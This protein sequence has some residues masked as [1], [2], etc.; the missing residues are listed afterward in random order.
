MAM[1]QNVKLDMLAG[2]S[3]G[4][5]V[6]LLVGLSASPVV[7]SVL[8]GVL[9]VVGAYLGLSSPAV[10]TD[11][12]RFERSRAQAWRIATFGIA[13][14]LA[15]LGGLAVRANNL[16]VA[17]PADRVQ[18]WVKAG[19]TPEQAREAVLI[20]DIGAVPRGW[21]PMGGGQARPSSS[22]LF[23]SETAPTCAR[24]TRSLYPDP[25]ERAK[26]FALQGPQ[27]AAIAQVATPLD[28]AQ[29][30]VLL[31]AAWRLVCEP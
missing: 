27:W 9:A 23:S 7:A 19:L 4:V 2:G 21:Q 26:A 15:V 30:D 8:S 11:A 22:A 29:R 10:A 5:L 28:T 1:V 14:T 12:A 6:G 31:D 25:A 18:R 3:I 13:C 20:Q 16:L 24:L 17:P